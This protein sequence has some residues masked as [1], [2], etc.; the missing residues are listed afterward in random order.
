MSETFGGR[1]EIGMLHYVDD[2]ND[3]VK[4]DSVIIM[5][6]EQAFSSKDG[7]QAE[8]NKEEPEQDK[9]EEVKEE[10]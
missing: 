5:S 3:F 6:T 2:E 7:E 9:A 10:Q 8:E 1:I 4:D